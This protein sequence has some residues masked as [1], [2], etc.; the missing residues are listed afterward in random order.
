MKQEKAIVAGG[1]FW[2]TESAF[3][4]APGVLDAVSGYIGGRSENPG[5]EEVC[6]GRS[7][8]YEA[9]EVTFDP[10]QISYEEVL[11]IFWR[12]IDP[13]DP[14]GQ[15]ADRGTQY[16]TAIFYTSD[17]QKHI[18]EESKTKLQKSGTFDQPIATAILPAARFY[19]AEEY[20]QDYSDKAPDHYKRYRIGSGREEFVTE[21]WKNKPTVCPLPKR[22][23]AKS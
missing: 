12:D 23:T 3:K 10:A 15:F 21:A 18:A 8:H 19:R 11:N 14:D 16:K 22:R 20:H 5:Y 6:S 17:E 2:C 4:G 7:G 13:T 9:V 1:C